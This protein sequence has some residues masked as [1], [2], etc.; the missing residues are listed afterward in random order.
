MV[1]QGL[2]CLWQMP[3]LIGILG[4]HMEEGE[5]QWLQAVLSST[6]T[7]QNMY[8]PTATHMRK[9]KLFFKRQAEHCEYPEQHELLPLHYA[10][11]TPLSLSLTD[12]YVAHTF[13]ALFSKKNKRE[14]LK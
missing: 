8:N 10:H 9:N 2:E 14:A 12:F 5:K 3:D 4:A 11:M 13:C 6:H 1:Q 7:L